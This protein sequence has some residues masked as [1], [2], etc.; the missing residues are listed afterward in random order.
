MR[1]FFRNLE[2][3]RVRYLLISG[4]A[5]VLYG[6]ATFSEDVDLWI[7]PTLRNVQHFMQ[8][9]RSSEAVVHKLTPPMTMRNLRRGHGFHFRLP[10][11][12][13]GIGYLDVMGRP[14]RVKSF[15]SALLR[16]KMIQTDWGRI[17]VVGIADLVELKKTRRL[18]DYDVISNLVRVRLQEERRAGIDLLR[19]GLMNCFQVELAQWIMSRWPTAVEIANKSRRVWLRALALGHSES[20]DQGI[21]AGLAL[22]IA[23][24]QQ[25]DTAYWSG[26]IQELRELRR[27]GALLIEGTAV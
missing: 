11:E 19:W 12:G 22:E 4:Q 16:C 27:T 6:A 17:P 25:R 1:S 18:A 3:H 21:R 2:G 8:A 9:L 13:S 7:C 14:P 15:R 5:S 23:T 10:E 20:A 26:I 24:L